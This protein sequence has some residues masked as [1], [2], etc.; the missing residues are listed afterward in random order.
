MMVLLVICLNLHQ[1]LNV[2]LIVFVVN[3]KMFCFFVWGEK[4]K[5]KQRAD[6]TNK[7]NMYLKSKCDIY[8]ETFNLGV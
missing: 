8:W 6:K 4:Q 3:D 1:K 7:D 5:Q 2:F